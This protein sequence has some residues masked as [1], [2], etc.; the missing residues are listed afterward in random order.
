MV[1]ADVCVSTCVSSEV[2]R[3]RVRVSSCPAAVHPPRLSAVQP[4]P[5]GG[6][7]LLSQAHYGAQSCRGSALRLIGPYSLKKEL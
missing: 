6:G 5:G 7:R 1:C 2:Q 4:A 3:L